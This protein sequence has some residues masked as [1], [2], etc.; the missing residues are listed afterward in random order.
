LSET[1]FSSNWELIGATLIR[2]PRGFDPEHKLIVDLK[3]KDFI[4]HR[5]FSDDEI[6][7]PDFVDFAVSNYKQCADYMS[8]LC[9][10]LEVDY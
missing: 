9:M 8:Y 4:A 10:A 1:Q 6:L 5:N 2:P 3:R 7:R